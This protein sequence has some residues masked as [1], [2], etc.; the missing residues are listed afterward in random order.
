M[1]IHYLPYKEINKAAH[2]S[3]G[4]QMTIDR[5]NLFNQHHNGVVRIIDLFDAAGQPTGTRVE[6]KIV[7]Q[8]CAVFWT[9]EEFAAA[10]K[11]S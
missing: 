3:M 11:G 2:I 5:I 4:M 8:W 6:V 1:P 9:L 7:N 10:A